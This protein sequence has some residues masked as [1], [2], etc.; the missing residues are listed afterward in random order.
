M[1]CFPK[2]GVGGYKKQKI[3]TKIYFFRVLL[4]HKC[5]ISHMLTKVNK[6]T[7]Y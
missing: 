5:D 7:L 4:H 1:K 6:R 2:K 3:S